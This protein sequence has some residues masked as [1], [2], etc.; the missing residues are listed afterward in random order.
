[1]DASF[2]NCYF[3]GFGLSMCWCNAVSL[4]HYSFTTTYYLFKLSIIP[5]KNQQT[6]GGSDKNMESDLRGK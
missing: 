2:L 4:S 1:V 5:V 3:S 6:Y